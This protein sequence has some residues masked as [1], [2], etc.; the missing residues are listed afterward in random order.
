MNE[1]DDDFV[2]PPHRV[3]YSHVEDWMNPKPYCE[4]GP[5]TIISWSV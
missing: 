4:A 2:L 3:A 1:H 5:I